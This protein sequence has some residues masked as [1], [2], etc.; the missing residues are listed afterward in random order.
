LHR[1]QLW[2]EAFPATASR[3]QSSPKIYKQANGA[4]SLVIPLY[5]QVQD[6]HLLGTGLC[7]QASEQSQDGLQCGF[8][9]EAPAPNS[10]T[11]EHIS[12][13]LGGDATTTLV[14]FII[15]GSTIS[16]VRFETWRP[17]VCR[18]GMLVWCKVGDAK[19]FYQL[20]DGLTREE[21]LDANRHGFQV[22]IAA[23]LGVLDKQKGFAKYSWLPPMN[24]PVLCE[25]DTFGKGSAPTEADDFIYGTVP[26]TQIAISGPFAQQIKHHTAIIGV[27]GSGK[28][29]LAFDLIRHTLLAGTKVICIDLTARYE[30]R[31]ADLHPVN[32]SISDELSAQL[33]AKLFAAETGKYNAGDEK[34]A[35]KECA[36][37][38][39][40]DIDRS[41][42]DFLQSSD[43]SKRLGIIALEEISNTKATLYIT[44]LYLTCLLHFARSEPSK[45]PPVLIV[46]E[47]AHTVM[48]EATTMGLGD[49]ESRGLV[50]KI[51]QIALQGRKYRVGLL[52]IAQR[53]ATVSKS[54]L[55]QCNTIIALSCFDETTLG[56]LGNV[57]GETDTKL[58]PNLPPLHA[59]VFGKGV[60]S[61]R[62]IMVKLQYKEIKAAAA[63]GDH[64]QFHYRP[65]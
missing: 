16:Q 46:V 55:T 37:K 42:R 11:T 21:S 17:D 22:A 48:P 26:G 6:E 51:S 35:L 1:N 53:T 32:L 23:Q 4:Q 18:E 27:T 20:T 3:C 34:K 52:I 57:F 65:H 24:T 43:D 41:L 29:E 54:V 47:E 62:P 9:Y 49:Y 39:R 10:L 19:V 56:F 31:L 44:N 7:V 63:F 12:A 38:L 30:R 15:E 61:E 25:P 13:H 40:D 2:S 28:T 59:V 64:H 5:E 45:C 33:S 60:R 8:I 14:G 58:I 50:G 36:D